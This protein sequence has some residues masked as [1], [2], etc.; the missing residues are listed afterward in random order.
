MGMIARQFQREGFDI[1]FDMLRRLLMEP[2]KPCPS[3]VENFNLKFLPVHL[4]FRD[5]LVKIRQDFI[6]HHPKR[7]KCKYFKKEITPISL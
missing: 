3:V 5:T 6:D 1:T 7:D 2:D 4:D